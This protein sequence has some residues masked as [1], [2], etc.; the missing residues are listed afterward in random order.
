MNYNRKD[1]VKFTSV[2]D[3]RQLTGTIVEVVPRVSAYWIRVDH[4]LNFQ[5]T[6]E[7]KGKVVGFVNR[8]SPYVDYFVFETMVLNK[9][10]RVDPKE[11]PKA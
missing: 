7:S 9:E 10:Q 4:K 6:L 3:K 11:T 8:T 5:Q 1:Y 2:L